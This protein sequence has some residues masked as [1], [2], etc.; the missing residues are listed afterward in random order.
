MLE[1]PRRYGEVGELLMRAPADMVECAAAITRD[2]EERKEQR[3]H[4]ERM[5]VDAAWRRYYRW[6]RGGKAKMVE[7]TPRPGSVGLRELKAAKENSNRPKP[8]TG[9]LPEAKEKKTEEEAGQAVYAA[10]EGIP[11][12]RAYKLLMYLAERLLDGIKE[13]ERQR[14][15]LQSIV[16]GGG[17]AKGG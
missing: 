3:D 7:R 13:Q 5:K 9:G 10:L 4:E 2:H 11:P 12:V 1:L 14:Q 8:A 17:G 16:R 6:A 15:A